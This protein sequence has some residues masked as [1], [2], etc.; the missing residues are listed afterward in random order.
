MS[1]AAAALTILL[2]AGSTVS[3]MFTF[4]DR[5]WLEIWLEIWLEMR[6]VNNA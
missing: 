4:G 3:T 1:M 2:Q 6:G 5:V